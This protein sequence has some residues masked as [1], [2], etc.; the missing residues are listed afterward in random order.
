MNL[1]TRVSALESD[2]AEIKDSLRL[3]VAGLNLDQPAKPAK[4][5]KAAPAKPKADSDFVGWLKETA[6]ARKARKADNA[7]L[8]AALR[9]VGVT[10][11][12]S[13]WALAKRYVAEGKALNVKALKAAN[14]RD[15]K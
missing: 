12:G 11:N 2:V 10:P 1:N 5:P 8:A 14:T 4:A 13:A 15:A 7:E 6:P 3:I 9:K